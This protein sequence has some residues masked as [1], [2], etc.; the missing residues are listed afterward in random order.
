MEIQEMKRSLKINSV[1]NSWR[2]IYFHM[3]Y[4]LKI[5]ILI[6]I[7]FYFIILYE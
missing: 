2:K 5:K 7:L 6:K 3:A 4:K 1:K